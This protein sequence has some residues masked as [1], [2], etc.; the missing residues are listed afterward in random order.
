MEIELEAVT[1]LRFAD[2]SPLRAASAIAPFGDGWLIAQDDATHAGWLQNGAVTPVRVLP[3]VDGL[4]VFDEAS[5]TKHLKP[6]FEAAC[7]I[8][9]DGAGAGAALFLGSGSTPGRMRSSLVSL[10]EGRARTLVTDLTPLYAV[11]AQALEVDP[12]YLNMEG[13][14]V[15]GGA[16]RWFQR[17]LP[18]AGIPTASVDLDLPALL[19]A[20]LGGADV[21]AVEVTNARH[22]DLGQ[23]AG[24]GFGITDAVALGGPSILVSAAAED[25]PNPRDD[26]PVVGCALALLEDTKATAVELLPTLDGRV[27]KVE[28][29]AILRLAE[30]GARVLATV[31]ADDYRTSSLALELRVTW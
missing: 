28:G 10:D 26:G 22:Y 23:V 25:T 11:V 7:E 31:D 9:D 15:I 17:G 14:C 30:A 21:A 24:V 18:A 5:G 20:V 8:P 27:L 12:T 6:D 4:E 19:A 2:G 16:L 29:L 13:A 1:P 3:A